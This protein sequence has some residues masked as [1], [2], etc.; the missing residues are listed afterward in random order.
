MFTGKDAASARYIYTRLSTITRSLFDERDDA[1][2][3]FRYY[4]FYVVVF[5]SLFIIFVVE[6]LDDD[7]MIVEPRHYVPVIPMVIILKCS[8]I[9]FTIFLT[10]CIYLF[11]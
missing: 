4:F 11:F 6:Y 1:V 9:I 8:L 2:C 7:G 5:L 10:I 3:M